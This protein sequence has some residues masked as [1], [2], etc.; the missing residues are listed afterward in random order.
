MTIFSWKMIPAEIRYE[1]HNNEF[2]AIIEVLK[3]WKHYLENS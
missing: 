2:L 3:T 1:T